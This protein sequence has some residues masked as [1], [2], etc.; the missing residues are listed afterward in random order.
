MSIRIP[1]KVDFEQ[2]M[3]SRTEEQVKAANRAIAPIRAGRSH[4]RAAN[5]AIAEIRSGGPH[6]VHNVTDIRT[7]LCA[8]LSTEEE[9]VVQ[10]MEK[11]S[12]CFYRVGQNGPMRYGQWYKDSRTAILQRTQSA[13]SIVRR[14]DLRTRLAL[15]RL[16][17][18]G[19]LASLPAEVK[20]LIFP[21]LTVREMLIVGMSC[22]TLDYFSREFLE[23]IVGE[24][25]RE[26]WEVVEVANRCTAYLA[27][28]PEFTGIISA[29]EQIR[30][31][32]RTL[33]LIHDVFKQKLPIS[34]WSQVEGAL[35]ALQDLQHGRDVWQ[36]R[37][38]LLPHQ[39]NR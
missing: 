32:E 15:C 38:G 33:Q 35:A 27:S 39:P 21:Y 23:E 28:L 36:R 26:E 16:F 6:G 7:I 29:T 18:Q 20:A 14:E 2:E 13:Q 22:R 19:T 11:V 3:Q 10:Q 5:R 8:P 31:P 4:D 30:N 34:L 37:Q 17:A 1:G 24:P 9:D 25:S 12:A